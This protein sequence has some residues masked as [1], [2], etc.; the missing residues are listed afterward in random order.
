MLQDS[1]HHQ[2]RGHRMRLP[3]LHLLERRMLVQRVQQFVHLIQHH[4]F[5]I[6]QQLLELIF[7]PDGGKNALISVRCA[8]DD[9]TGCLHHL[10]QL[11]FKSFCPS[12][13]HHSKPCSSISDAFAENLQSKFSGRSDYQ[14]PPR[15]ASF[16]EPREQG[17]EVC[18]RLSAS[19]WRL[20]NDRATRHD[21]RDGNMLDGK[22]R[23]DTNCLQLLM[24]L[25]RAHQ[26]SELV[27]VC[28][29]LDRKGTER[30]QVSFHVLQVV[31]H[32]FHLHLGQLFFSY[33]L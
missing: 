28:R 18:E 7:I 16:L 17:H 29:L 27:W 6:A 21:R 19:R 30:F 20:D 1:L 9:G 2:A 12:H 14:P 10:I 11:I 31:N 15:L 5:Q 32:N 3:H 24:H 26:S 23:R 33:V 8:N 22:R 25:G 13:N 4:H